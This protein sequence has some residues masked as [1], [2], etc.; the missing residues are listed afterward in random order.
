[1]AVQMIS[2]ALAFKPAEANLSKG[3]QGAALLAWL[4]DMQ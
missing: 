3:S 1:M 2:L 4:I